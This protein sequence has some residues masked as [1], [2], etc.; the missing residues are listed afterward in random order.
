VTISE[1]TT[2]TTDYL[3]A[4]ISIVFGIALLRARTHRATLLWA[5]GFLLLAGAGITGGT[6]HGFRLMMSEGAH[7]TLWNITLLLIG[8]SAGFMIS[9]ALSTHTPWN[10][11]NTRWLSAGLLLSAAGVVIQQSHLA[12]HPNFNHNDMF[13]SVQIVA[14]YCF[15]RGAKITA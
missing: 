1:P 3:L 15:Y 2:L 5:I 6:F 7:R 4:V 8:A 9:A 13:H 12:I 11:P 14:L 10:G